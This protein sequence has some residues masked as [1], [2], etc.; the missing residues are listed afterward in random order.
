MFDN[1]C[2]LFYLLKYGERF[3]VDSLVFFASTDRTLTYDQKMRIIEFIITYE[4]DLRVQES[5]WKHCLLYLVMTGSL[6][7]RELLNQLQ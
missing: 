3:G 4:Q 2:L 5:S 6:S 1:D 7:E